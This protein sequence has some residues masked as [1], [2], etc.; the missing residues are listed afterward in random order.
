[1]SGV[2]KK[3][4]GTTAAGGGFTAIEDVFSTYLYTGDYNT[5]TLNKHIKNNVPLSN[6]GTGGTSVNF[7]GDD[8]LTRSDFTSNTDGKEITFSAWILFNDFENNF[9]FSSDPSGGGSG[10]NVGYHTG[11]LRFEAYNTGGSIVSQW[12]VDDS[13]TPFHQWFHLCFSVNT[14]SGVGATKVYI[15]DVAATKESVTSSNQDIDRTSTVQRL[16]ARYIDYR[17][18]GNLAHVFMDYTYRDLDIVSN[19]RLFIDENGGSTDPSTLSALNP[20]MYCPLT[21]DYTMG[22][23]LGTGGDFTSS[24]NPAFSTLGTEATAGNSDGGMVWIK[25]R[26]STDEHMLFDTERGA[27]KSLSSNTTSAEVTNNPDTLTQFLAD[28]FFLG[29]DVAVN[30]TNE[31]YASWTFRKAPRFFDVVT[32]TGTGSTRTVNHN[33]G[34]APGCI[35]VKRTDTTGDWQVYHRS[36]T[37]APQTDYLVLNSTAATV[38]SNTRWNDTLPTDSVFTVGTEATVNAS[39][40][41]YV[42]YLFAHDPLGPSG[43]GSDGLIACGSY[44][45]NGSAN[46][47]EIDLGWEPQWLLVKNASAIE[48]WYM[49]DVMRGMP[50]G[51][52]TKDLYPNTNA[53]E[54]AYE[55]TKN[56]VDPTPTG[57]KVKDSGALMNG[58][59]QTIIY[60]AIRRGP[61]RVP[62]SGT[63]VF[64]AGYGTGTVPGFSS[65][66]PVDFA[67]FRNNIASSGPEPL[68]TARLTQERYLSTATAAAE[69]SGPNFKFDKMDGWAVSYASSAFSWMFR[70]A[71]NFFDVVAYTG[72]GTAG[73]TVPHNLGVAPEMMW[74]KNRAT[75][76]WQVYHAALPNTSYMILNGDNVETT[77]GADRWNSTDPTDSVFTLGTA[78]T[79]NNNNNNYIA[80]LFASLDGISKVGSYTGNG[81]SQTINCGFTSGAR[82]VLI[83]SRSQGNWIVY[84]SA[85]GIV[86]G[87]DPALFLNTTNAEDAGHDQID[88]T[89]SGFIVVNDNFESSLRRVNQPGVNYIFYAIA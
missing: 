9:V 66:F 64:S 48:S 42:A 50:V 62:E 20:I 36:N 33:L 81:S 60:I 4:M 76:S 24:G 8:Y 39:G 72:N 52:D 69:L 18:T 29:D 34:V 86:S 12:H 63:E 67:I 17:L 79:V 83:R 70:R 58:S 40:G 10:V 1:M 3:L 16:A 53:N 7:D 22:K 88:P 54:D 32:W 30:T 23:N 38:D 45:G 77:S 80:Y 13:N 75:D 46:G 85:R 14:A 43:D 35:F 37:A 68:A 6:F 78:T 5:G 61:M 11:K 19:R 51:G 15:N 25:N 31:N 41:T 56:L 84:D 26:S 65:G 59:G 57:F 82:F 89:S 74:V 49:F 47:P 21:D 73:G 2:S 71:P 55:G 27:T 44:T 28:G 87:N